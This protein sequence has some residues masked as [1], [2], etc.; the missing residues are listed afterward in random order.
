M[1]VRHSAREEMTGGRPFVAADVL[2]LFAAQALLATCTATL[3]LVLPVSTAALAI[4]GVV[5]AAA[6]VTALAGKQRTAHR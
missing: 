1:A 6:A 2:G 3:A 4:T 5:A